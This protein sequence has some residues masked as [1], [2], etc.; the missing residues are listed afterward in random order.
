MEIVDPMLEPEYN[1][2]EA[3]RMIRVA[4]LCTNASP[5]LRPTM[6]QVVS[7]LEGKSVIEE[8]AIDPNTYLSMLQSRDRHDKTNLN[9]RE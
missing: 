3:L 7:M 9:S 1:K 6:S 2:E 4:L 8:S 5:S